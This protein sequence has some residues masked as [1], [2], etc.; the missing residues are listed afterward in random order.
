MPAPVRPSG[1]CMEPCDVGGTLYRTVMTCDLYVKQALFEWMHLWEAR[2]GEGGS[3]AEL[4]H[5]AVHPRF[6][7]HHAGLSGLIQNGNTI[8][9]EKRR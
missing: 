7:V 2:L 9:L 6:R 4:G 3:L 1:K 5:E 8:D